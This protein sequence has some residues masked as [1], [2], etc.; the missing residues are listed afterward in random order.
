M[1]SSDSFGQATLELGAR[2][3]AIETMTD[4]RCL[5]SLRFSTVSAS[6]HI[7]H[8]FPPKTTRFFRHSKLRLLCN[9]S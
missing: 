8:E 4:A 9:L 6:R 1:T 7:G 3:A 2:N 5:V